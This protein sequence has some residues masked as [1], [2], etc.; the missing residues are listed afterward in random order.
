M[1]RRVTETIP[2]VYLIGYRGSGKS[3]VGRLLAEKLGRP[4]VDT[5]RLVE[6][7]AG[8]SILTIFA[9]EGEDAFRDLE[10][11][12]VQGV[13]ERSRAG[14]RLVAALGGGVI[15]RPAS[16]T[17]LRESGCVVWLDAGAETLRQ[18]ILDDPRSPAD[19]P[20]LSGV[21]AAGEIEA[22]LTKRRAL[23]LAAAHVEVSTEGLS[24]DGVAERVLEELA[25]RSWT[26]GAG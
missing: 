8:K 19:R 24:P 20:P 23:Y 17:R 18:R 26:P 7:K 21:S 11:A 16:V 3:S 14:E 13:A 2:S 6:E 25:G 4:F 15:V 12:V 5:D 22:V 10:E 9:G 1:D